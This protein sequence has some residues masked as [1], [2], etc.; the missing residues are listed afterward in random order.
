MKK[1][2]LL[3]SLPLLGGEYSTASRWLA[4][5]NSTPEQMEAI[6]RQFRGFD[7]AMMEVGYRYEAIQKA[8]DRGNYPLATYHWEKI[9]TAMETGIIRRPSRKESAEAFFLH[10]IH[11]AFAEILRSHDTQKIRA[12]LP[13]VQ[14]ACNACHAD[15]KV[16]F[17]T[18]E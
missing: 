15:Q 9:R 17:I 10:S 11:P 4:D 5:L 16:G 12:T 7:T 1:F 14:S 2:L 6:Q 3:L 13:A 18:I 8:I